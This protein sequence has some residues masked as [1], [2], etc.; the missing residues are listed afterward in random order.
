SPM[1]VLAPAK[2]NLHLRVGK[3]RGDGFHPILTWMCTVGLFDTLI[4]QRKRDGR[5]DLACDLPGLPTDHGNLVIKA[6]VS[7]ADS[8]ANTEADRDPPKPRSPEL[9]IPQPPGVPDATEIARPT[10]GQGGARND[11]G[12]SLSLQKRI[13]VGAGL[14]GG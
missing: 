6:A 3:P 10:L 2:I 7:M 8:L 1:R 11:F 5:I 14:G 13:P 9:P 4:L 12:L